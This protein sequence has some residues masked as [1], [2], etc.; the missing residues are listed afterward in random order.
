MLGVV[1]PARLVFLMLP[2]PTADALRMTAMLR[3]LRKLTLLG[4]FSVVGLFTTLV[5]AA[6]IAAVLSRAL[7]TMQTE[8]A[9]R[10]VATQV[11]TIVMPVLEGADLTKP[12]AGRFLANLE[13]QLSE[14]LSSDTVQINI[15]GPG[16]LL[17]Y[18]DDS[19]RIGGSFPNAELRRA[20]SG[21]TV[22][23]IKE[24]GGE[25]GSLSEAGAARY[26]EVYTPIRLS[27][28]GEVQGAYEIHETTEALD[29]RIAGL[30]TRAWLGSLLG[31]LAL[32][33]SLYV[34]MQRASRQ[35]VAQNAEIGQRL[36]ESLLLN[37]VIMAASSE[38]AP[39]D[40][41]AAVCREVQ[42]TVGI[43]CTVDMADVQSAVP[44]G[45]GDHNGSVRT[46]LY[47]PMLVGDRELGRLV[48][49]AS[50]SRPLDV[51]TER[52]VR[53]VAAAAAVAL[54]KASLLADL[55]R[56]NSEL[57]TAYDRTIESLARAL[58][59]RD[60][61][62]EGHSRR[63]TDLTVRLLVAMGFSDEEVIHGRR[64]ALLHDIG[65]LGIPDSILHKPGPLDDEEWAVMKTH[66][67]LAYE[68]LSPIEH[69]GPAL[70]IPYLH[71]EKW[72]GT[73][74]PLGL[75]AAE[76]PIA[77]RAFAMVDVWDALS[78]D[79]PYRH[80][81]PQED[82]TAHMLA[83]AGSHFDP[84]LVPLFLHVVEEYVAEEG[85]PTDRSSDRRRLA[86]G[87]PQQ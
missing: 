27:A 26:L 54:H 73:G 35:L 84:E 17:L 65:K 57:S 19:A 28:S 50:A 51:E 37:H 86:G 29:Q 67:V 76:I 81:W 45:N 74:Y 34:I 52:V 75:S 5:M 56:A 38:N 25:A 15:W 53:G 66:T 55:E 21:E 72:D 68:M 64:G 69:L 2:G 4:K 7:V 42:D 82:V 70:D 47:V 43:P 39:D 58:D 18:S 1:T 9:G 41:L 48:L 11:H 61:E 59:K 78:S 14:H 46:R 49:E 60:E 6:F 83:T 20:L 32:F 16:S 30:K 87:S 36:G 77:A 13:S 33:G 8:E 31:F 79:R 63:V 10:D 85:L 12:L 23:Q 40:V 44:S 3:P 22:S 24:T 80:A 71:H 62:T